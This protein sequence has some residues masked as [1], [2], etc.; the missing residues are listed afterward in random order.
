MAFTQNDKEKFLA[1]LI[2]TRSS[3]QSGEIRLR[4]QGNT[5]EADQVSQACDRLTDQ[6]DTLTAQLMDDWLGAANKAIADLGK[7]SGAVDDAVAAIK[8]QLKIAQTVVKLTGAIDD[9]V[10]IAKKA[11]LAL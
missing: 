7:R 9:A 10:A 3:A 4:F 6:I 2:D 8:K 1:A 5:A 11:L